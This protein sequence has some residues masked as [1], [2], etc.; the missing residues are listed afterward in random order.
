[1]LL[2]VLFPSALVMHLHIKRVNHTKAE[3]V[4]RLIAENGWTEEELQREKDRY[5]FLDL[6]SYPLSFVCKRARLMCSSTIDRQGEPL[7]R[8]H[9]LI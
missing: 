6:V 5:A 3:N 9:G 7:L 1:M 4:A 8:L 2:L